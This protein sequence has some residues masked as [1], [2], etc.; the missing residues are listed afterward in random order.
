MATNKISMRKIND[1][2]IKNSRFL[3]HRITKNY[4]CNKPENEDHSRPNNEDNTNTND[5][6]SFN[7]ED[8][9]EKIDSKNPSY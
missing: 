2:T 3:L 7:K 6:N 8:S 9:K 5:T 1:L 4:F